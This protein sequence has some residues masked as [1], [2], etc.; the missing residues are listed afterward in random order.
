MCAS[1][2]EFPKAGEAAFHLLE[3]VKLLAAQVFL[4]GA[5]FSIFSLYVSIN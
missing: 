4:L 3:N 1:V 5:F 2:W